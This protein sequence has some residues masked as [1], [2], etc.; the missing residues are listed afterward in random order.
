MAKAAAVRA[1]N[2]DR[3]A[4]RPFQG[5]TPVPPVARYPHL[6]GQFRQLLL[7]RG[8]DNHGLD[9]FAEHTHDTLQQDLRTKR[10]PGLRQ[11]H[12]GTAT[13]AKN[14]AAG[15]CMVAMWVR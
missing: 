7:R 8:H 10:Q 13:P 1:G 6:A 4:W 5:T 15:H 14:N 3:P 2:A 12:A 9:Q 11:T